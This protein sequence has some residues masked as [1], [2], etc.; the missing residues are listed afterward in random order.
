MSLIDGSLQVKAGGFW[1]VAEKGEMACFS[2]RPM[3]GKPRPPTEKHDFY[4]FM[5]FLQLNYKRAMIRVSFVQRCIQG[6]RANQ[7][8]QNVKASQT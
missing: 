5:F 6:W 4:K 3:A 1:G 8:I 7:F 2:P